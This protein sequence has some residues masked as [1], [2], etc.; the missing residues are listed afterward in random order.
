MLKGY[1]KY[2][3][4]DGYRVYDK[5]ENVEGITMLGCMV[6]ARRYFEK[7]KENDPVRSNH[8]LT[9]VQ[10]LDLLERQMKGS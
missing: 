8:F 5:C 9:Q 1:Q 3:Q 7:A 10:L 4:T 6:H 2:L